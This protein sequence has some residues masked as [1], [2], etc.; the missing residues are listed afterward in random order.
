MLIISIEIMKTLDEREIQKNSKRNTSKYR[1]KQG[2][3]R[4]K[5]K[6]ESWMIL[7]YI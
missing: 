5:Q 3:Q 1:K 2:E 4:L 6:G 7:L